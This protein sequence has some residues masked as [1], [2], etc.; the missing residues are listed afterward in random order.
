ME[1][2][3]IFGGCGF[4]GSWIV[5]AFLKKGYIVS[6]F[7]LK[8][9]KELLSHVVGEDIN[10]IKFINGD[11]TN[12]E[13]VQESINDMDHV[14]NLAGLMTPDC[15]SNP[16]LGAKVNLLGSINVFEALK[17]N[18]NKFLV[19]AS[20]AGVFGQK[21]HYYPF[22]ETHYGAYKLAVEGVA[23]AYL[24]EDGISSVG[25]RPYVIYG[26]GREVGGTAGVTLACKAAK[27]GES[28]TV[29]FSGK[30]GFVYVQDVVDL[31]EMSIAQ[32]PSGALTFN[33]NGITADV[34]EFINL[35]K[36]N[37]PLSDI[38]IEGDPLSV[39]DEIRGNEP[40]KTFKKFKY[41]SLEDGIKRTIDFY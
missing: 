24:N 30:A 27:Q 13:Q 39:V 40:S 1:K 23:R 33:I 20:S 3:I 9:Q 2:I 21:D 7:D 8:I 32:I 37:I 41:T 38:G 19:Y 17:K 18:N 31:V 25:I 4:L 34:S 6:I 36:K 11:I 28:Y 15:S 16:I 29:N 14:I 10:K 26:P 5:K 35:I 12:Y 22:P